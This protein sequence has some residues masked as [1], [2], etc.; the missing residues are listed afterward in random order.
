VVKGKTTVEGRGEKAHEIV[1]LPVGEIADNWWNPNSETAERFNALFESIM[2]VG[3]VENIQVVPICPELQEVMT[4][5]EDRAAVAGLMKQGKKWL[6]VQGSHRFEAARIA[7]SDKIREIPAVVLQPTD[8]S[9]MKALSVRMNVI[10]GRIDPVKFT[11]LFDELSREQA[12]SVV[13][14]MMGVATGGEFERLYQ[15]VKKTL[16]P[17]LQKELEKTKA[18]LRT[19]DDLGR[20]LN[21]LFARFGSDLDYSFM[22]FTWGGKVH[23][24]VR[25]RKDAATVLASVKEMCRQRQIDMNDLLIYGFKAAMGAEIDWPEPRAED[26]GID[27]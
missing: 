26:L 11:K 24:M 21:E 2:D 18:E 12:E 20:V 25:L 9:K 16:P 14:E 22:S 4:K 8:V 23:T 6:V 17:E 1:F 7:G 3:F 5:E 10:K 15:S 19:I 27:E 13:K